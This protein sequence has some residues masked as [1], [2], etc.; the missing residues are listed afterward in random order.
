MSSSILTRTSTEAPF[1]PLTDVYMSNLLNSLNPLMGKSIVAK[2]E[3]K[4]LE[5][6]DTRPRLL[7]VL[8]NPWG[9]LS[10]PTGFA[11]ETYIPTRQ[12]CMERDSSKA[13]SSGDSDGERVLASSNSVMSAGDW[14]RSATHTAHY[15]RH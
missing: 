1:A 4:K 10:A 8:G 13:S 3:K 14:L 11:S 5:K 12:N 15:C 2:S 9:S 7:G 6:E